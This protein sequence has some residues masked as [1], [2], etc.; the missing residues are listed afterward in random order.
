MVLVEEN[1]EGAGPIRPRAL[2]NINQ[3]R[4]TPKGLAALNRDVRRNSAV[5]DEQ[6]H[7]AFS[8]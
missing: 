6:Q 5:I 4:T 3:L 7:W 8:G 2:L 1:S